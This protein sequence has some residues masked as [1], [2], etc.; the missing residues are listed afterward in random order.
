[1]IK[2]ILLDADGIVIQGRKKYFSEILSEEKGIDI[3]IVKQFYFNEYRNC[4]VGK[5]NLEEEISKYL[6]RWKWDKSVEEL[7]QYWFSYDG[8]PQ[9]NILKVVSFLRSNGYKVY[10]ASDHTKYRAEDIMNRMKMKDFFDGVFF[11]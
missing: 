10:I 3:N 11:L 9:D 5:A 4:V 8:K 1:M 7:L 6:K 2:A